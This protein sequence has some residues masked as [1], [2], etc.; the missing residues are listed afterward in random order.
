LAGDPHELH[1]DRFVDLAVPEVH[2]QVLDGDPHLRSVSTMCR[3]SRQ[4]RNQGALS[5]PHP[6]SH[7]L[8][9]R[10]AA[11]VSENYEDPWPLQGRVIWLL[12]TIDVSSRLLVG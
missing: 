3:S 10:T 8:S 4:P 5:V 7:N 1:S 9:A 2:P 11:T 6:R 12:V